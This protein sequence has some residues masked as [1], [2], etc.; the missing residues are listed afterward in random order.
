MIKGQIDCSMRSFLSSFFE[1]YGCFTWNGFSFV[2]CKTVEATKRALDG[3]Q[4]MFG[5]STWVAFAF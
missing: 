2:T 1:L 3:L 4:N 5:A